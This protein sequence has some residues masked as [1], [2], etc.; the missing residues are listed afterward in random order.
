MYVFFLLLFC[1]CFQLY[2]EV[3]LSSRAAVSQGSSVLLSLASS[4]PDAA[5]AE[6]V[7][8]LS[9]FLLTRAGPRSW[10]DSF[11]CIFVSLCYLF[12]SFN[13]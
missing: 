10:F 9:I 13:D 1:R 2:Y 5:L 7:L 6:P 4:H 12:A 3:G 8:P 11:S